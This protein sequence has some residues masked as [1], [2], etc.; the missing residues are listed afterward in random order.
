[1]FVSAASA[2]LKASF[3][4]CRYSGLIYA[5]LIQTPNLVEQ[6]TFNAT[7]NSHVIDVI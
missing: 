4:R 3:L 1:M 7:G 2:I 5:R 6:C